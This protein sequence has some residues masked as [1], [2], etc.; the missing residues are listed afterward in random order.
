MIVAG[1]ET[2]T[3]LLSHAWYW[4]WKNPDEQS[5]VQRERDCIPGW[6]EETL[7][8]DTSSQLLARRATEDIPMHGTTIPAG[9]KVVLLAGS[10]NRDPRAFDSPD[11]FRVRRFGANGTENHASLA[12][13]GIG[14]HYCLGASLARLEARVALEELLSIV[15]DWDIDESQTRRV[16]SVN[17]RGFETL[18]TSV[19]TR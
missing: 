9:S 14:R 18:P 5:I 10:A 11:E 1:N 2:T 16:H 13:F 19:K 6:V 7:R 3:K 15:T 4:A 17:V 12:S 8:Y